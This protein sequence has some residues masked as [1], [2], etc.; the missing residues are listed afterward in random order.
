MNQP[1]QKV[2]AF[3]TQKRD[4]VDSLLVFKHPTAGIQ[5]P[6]G[7]VETGE[8]IETA[9]K[10]E[11]YEETGIQNVEI[12]EY[13]GCFDNELS[14][15]QRI[16]TETTKVYIKPDL[17][18]VPY[19]DKLTRGLTVDF[20]SIR[21]DF[22]HITY[23]EYDDFPNPTYISYIISGW[24]PNENISSQKTRHFFQLT[25]TEHTED[26]W[27]LRSDR[28]HIFQPFW[29]ALSPKPKIVSPQNRWLDFVYEKLLTNRT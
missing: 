5:L 2:T 18:A 28:G 10:R 20:H 25:T 3:I 9:V 4:G 11:T 19:K 22:T 21:Q 27:E 7:T 16:I 29:T 1:I 13:L 12:E 17:D 6:A 14:K 26:I 23:F 15:E 24:V 8:D